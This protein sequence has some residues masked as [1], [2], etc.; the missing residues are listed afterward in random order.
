MHHSVVL[1][2]TPTNNVMN[3]S[4]RNCFFNEAMSVSSNM[5]YLLDFVKVWK[6]I[7]GLTIDAASFSL[8]STLLYSSIRNVTF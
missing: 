5:N 2:A 8:N 6:E 1:Y 7:N 3:K 4:H